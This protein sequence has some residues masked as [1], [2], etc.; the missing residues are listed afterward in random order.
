MQR[1]ASRCTGSDRSGGHIQFDKDT[2]DLREPALHFAGDH[3]AVFCE[4]LF[5][6][7]GEHWLAV[8]VAEQTVGAGGD[9]GGVGLP[10]GGVDPEFAAFD[11]EGSRGAGADI[12]GAAWRAWSPGVLRGGQG[13]RRDACAT[14]SAPDLAPRDEFGE[15]FGDLGGGVGFFVTLDL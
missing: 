12:G 3:V 15:A 5:G 2:I 9:G 10:R 1:C 7:Y 11:G 8:V 6:L 4:E 13:H 14:L